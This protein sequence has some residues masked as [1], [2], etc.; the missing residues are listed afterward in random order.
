MSG[1]R[2]LSTSKAIQSFP[3]EGKYPL[4]YFPDLNLLTLDGEAP[5]DL[6]IAESFKDTLLRFFLGIRR[7]VA[8]KEALQTPRVLFVE[9]WRT[10]NLA[11]TYCYAGAGPSPQKRIEAGALKALIKGYSFRRV[12]VFGGEPLID[13]QFLI[14]LYKDRQWD[15]LFFSSNGI[16]LDHP[17]TQKLITLPNV[18]FQ[19]SLEP[20]EWS[21]RVTVDGKKQFDLLVPRLR[22]LCNSRPQLRVTIPCD[23]PYVPLKGF[24]EGLVQAIGS[25]QFSISYWPAHAAAPAPWLENWIQES[26]ELVRDD[27]DGRYAGKLPGCQLGSYFLEMAEKGFRFCNCNAA[28]GS[29]AVSPEGK[30]HGCHELAIAESDRDNVST[31]NEPQVIDEA[32]RLDLVYKWSNGMHDP[33]CT[34]CSARYVCG[35]V[36]FV[37]E[38]PNAA[39]LFLQHMLRLVLTEMVRYQPTETL[40]LASRSEERL[41]QLLSL[42]EK[43]RE[44]VNSEKWKQLAYGELPL[45]E[46]AELAE[47]LLDT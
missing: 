28:Y 1:A 21:S 19:V 18:H 13:A 46:A 39:C 33:C 12:L 40:A 35:G 27:Y 7:L 45:A 4:Y 14:E 24:I 47:R 23:A 31:S 44:E 25:L 9:P 10:C 37:L 5:S 17:S 29:V 32:K 30:L 36:C 22:L 26:Y 38:R 8:L 41:T 16:L 43:L 20:R 6:A 42:K 11:C 2:A 34:Q 15:S 3:T